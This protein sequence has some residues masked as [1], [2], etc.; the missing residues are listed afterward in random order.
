[1][2]FSS[3]V[4]SSS[5]QLCYF[6]GPLTGSWNKSYCAFFP[7]W[8][9]FCLASAE[10]SCLIW[11]LRA[12]PRLPPLTRSPRLPGR[13]FISV[14]FACLS[15]ASGFAFVSSTTSPSPQT[16]SRP[17]KVMWRISSASEEVCVHSVISVRAWWDTRSP[18]ATHFICWT[19]V[20]Y[21]V[22]DMSW[23]ISGE[24]VWC[25]RITQQDDA[26]CLV[27][28]GQQKNRKCQLCCL[29]NLLAFRR[30]NGQE[31]FYM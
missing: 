9:W 17:M 25:L 29:E 6:L 19:V 11:R 18:G 22:W 10:S 8:C 23:S 4:I 26:A 7:W 5:L 3:P 30:S 20:L 16:Q 28:A 13:Q 15:T 12:K 2:V 31:V 24:M 1:M 14:T 21:P 27:Y